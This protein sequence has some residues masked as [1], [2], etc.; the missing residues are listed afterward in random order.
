[1]S[2][3]DVH[4]EESESSCLSELEPHDLETGS[5]AYI[6]LEKV[7]SGRM[8]LKDIK[9]L[10]PAEQTSGLESFHNI[11]CYFAPK[12]THFS[13]QMRARLFLSVLHFNKNTSRSQATTT[14]GR[15]QFSIS[16]PKGRKGDAIAKE[17]KVKQTFGYVDELMKELLL[18]RETYPSYKSALYI[19]A[20]DKRLVVPPPLADQ[21]NRQEKENVIQQHVNRFNNE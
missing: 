17:V 19:A 8:L 15:P 3:D 14:E 13:L 10:S 6:E 12:S 21:A 9:K 2:V 16:Y 18:Y 7:I 5:P 11:V 20:V 1:M 4:V